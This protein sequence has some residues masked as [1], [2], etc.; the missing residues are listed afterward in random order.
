MERRDLAL[1]SILVIIAFALLAVGQTPRSDG[2]SILSVLLGSVAAAAR[3]FHDEVLFHG[4]V[5]PALLAPTRNLSPQL[6]P[7]VAAR[8][9]VIALALVGVVAVQRWDDAGWT[10]FAGVLTAIL[11]ERDPAGRLPVFANAAARIAIVVL[12]EFNLSPPTRATML[13]SGAGALASIGLVGRL[14]PKDAN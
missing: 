1:I 3:A 10:F 7:A 5:R 6:S 14:M 11:W 9:R 12:M 8:F 13:L 2:A 4:V